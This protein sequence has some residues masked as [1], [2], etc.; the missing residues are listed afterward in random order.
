MGHVFN[1]GG[2]LAQRGECP[3]HGPQFYG[4]SHFILDLW[5]L[6]NR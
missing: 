4:S 2:G 1:V 6:A 5:G 3:G